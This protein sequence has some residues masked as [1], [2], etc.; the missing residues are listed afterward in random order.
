V[1]APL[2]W[3]VFP[4]LI[5]SISF[6]FRRID[7]IV[8]ITLT[9]I[10]LLLT[11]IAWL[12]PIGEL[13]NLGSWYFS[14]N[15]NLEIASRQFVLE[16][17]DRWLI[18]AIYFTQTYFYFGSKFT[19]VSSM[20]LPLGLI[21]SGL[22]VAS[23]S[24]QP[25]LYAALLIEMAVLIGVPLL[26]PPGK[27]AD[28][29]IL[30]YITFLSL[31]LPFMIIG[32]GMISNIELDEPGFPNILSSLVVLGIG[33]AFLLA[34]FP[35]NPWVPLILE[36]GNPYSSVFVLTVFPISV[37]A[38]VIRFTNQY[39]W[40]IESNLFQYFGILMVI[41]GGAWVMFQRNLGRILG[42][43]II[44]DIGY[45]LLA[46]SQS[47]G[48]PIFVGL[49]IPRIISYGIW[50]LGLSYISD[51][52]IDLNFRSVKGFGRQFPLNVFGVLAANFSLAGFPLFA[53]FPYLLWLWSKLAET[54]TF[55]AIVLLLSS[56]GLM[57][58]AMRSLAVLVMGSEIGEAKAIA[59]TRILNL[60]F[61]L[62]VLTLVIM[63]LFPNWHS[64]MLTQFAP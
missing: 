34:V 57:I 8:W 19:K 52:G 15:E 18:I 21:L 64:L 36:N 53:S 14:I 25:L 43:A 6:F 40:I 38:L 50:G 11:L 30:V 54:S 12:L 61:I 27:K 31:G 26:S 60:L 4:L 17:S 9:L 1:S 10:S 20:F 23:I 42:Y 49:L 55:I 32:G 28:H 47:E 29:A 22:L 44:I 59:T 5:G 33:F 37:I 63:G 7:N 16:N 48:F 24:V 39:P 45:S 3:I 62:G 35:L 46:I 58:G 13:V 2:I 41:T 56:V 51:Q